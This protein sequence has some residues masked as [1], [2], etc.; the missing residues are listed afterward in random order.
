MIEADQDWAGSGRCGEPSRSYKAAAGGSQAANK[1]DWRPLTGKRI[2][3]LSDNDEP[4]RK[5]AETDAGI[6]ARLTP[7]SVVW[8]QPCRNLTEFFGDDKPLGSITTGDCDQFR[9]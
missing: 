4:G 3:T 5:Y 2:I 1:T 9:V 7:A 6:L 8:Q